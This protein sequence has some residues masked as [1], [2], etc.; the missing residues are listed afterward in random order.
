MKIVVEPVNYYVQYYCDKYIMICKK[1][2]FINK[3][4]L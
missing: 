1:M 3:Y 2:E 4:S